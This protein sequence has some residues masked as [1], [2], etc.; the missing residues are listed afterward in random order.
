M[1]PRG[2]RWAVDGGPRLPTATEL[3]EGGLVES[4]DLH[5]IA[6]RVRQ[7]LAGE[8]SKKYP[9]EV[10]CIS[11]LMCRDWTHEL[12]KELRAAGHPARHEKGIVWGDHP[13]DPSREKG[14]GPRGE[15]GDGDWMPHH[16]VSIGTGNKISSDDTIID[17]SSDQFN[18]YS[19]TKYPEVIVAKR[20]E[21]KNHANYDDLGKDDTRHFMHKFESCDDNNL[22]SSRHSRTA[23]ELIEAKLSEARKLLPVSKGTRAGVDLS[24]HLFPKL[25]GERTDYVSPSVAQPSYLRRTS[26]VQDTIVPSAVNASENLYSAR[27]GKYFLHLSPEAKL[28]IVG[29]VELGHHAWGQKRHRDI[30]KAVASHEGSEPHPLVVKE[31]ERIH[32]HVVRRAVKAGVFSKAPHPENESEKMLVPGPRFDEFNKQT[33]E[34]GISGHDSAH[35]GTTGADASRRGELIAR[36]LRDIHSAVSRAREDHRKRAS[37]KGPDWASAHKEIKY[38]AFDYFTKHL[39]KRYLEAGTPIEKSGL[40]L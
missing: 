20:H 40:G 15:F 5:K 18:K 33:Y 3:I 30:V 29:N 16:Y 34:T 37:S 32:K 36:Y 2:Y 22:P 14:Y 21:L 10:G 35:H 13:S 17:I 7:R 1:V 31:A 4:S 39:N 38:V 19:T 28:D 8:R 23:T 12:T 6:S 24:T 26:R 11:D 25:A 9:D 27:S